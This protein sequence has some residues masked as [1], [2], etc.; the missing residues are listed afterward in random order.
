ML[1]VSAQMKM[2]DDK[3]LQKYLSIWKLSTEIFKYINLVGIK[4]RL[5]YD[6]KN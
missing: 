5:Y 4:V 2:G 3:G 1:S 6:P